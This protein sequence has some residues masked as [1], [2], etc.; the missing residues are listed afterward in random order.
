MKA[1]NPRGFQEGEFGIC[2]TVRNM[3]RPTFE[4]TAPDD[5]PTTD[6]ER[7]IVHELLESARMAEIGDLSVDISCLAVD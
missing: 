1:F 3:N 5:G 4:N 2:L 6:F 7:M